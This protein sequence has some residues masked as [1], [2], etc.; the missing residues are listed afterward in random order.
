MK[1]PLAIYLIVGAIVFT[2]MALIGWEAEYVGLWVGGAFGFLSGWRA[3][4]N[5]A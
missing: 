5:Y 1:E 3:R 4:S 2:V